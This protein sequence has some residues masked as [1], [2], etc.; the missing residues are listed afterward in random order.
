MNNNTTYS[1]RTE[2][3]YGNSIVSTYDNETNELICEETFYNNSLINI[4]EYVNKNG[5]VYRI[6]KRFYDNGTLSE[7]SEY[8]GN[9]RVGYHK[10]Y[11]DNGNLQF[12]KSY[13][14]SGRLHGDSFVY[15]PD[16]SVVTSNVYIEGVIIVS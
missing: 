2:L 7:F 13:N 5:V 4:N 11:Y 10:K 12:F 6:Q 14:T 9:L 1:R 15:H 8:I 16:G 3:E